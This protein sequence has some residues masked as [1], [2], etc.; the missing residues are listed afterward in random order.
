M[1]L[2]IEHASL[3]QLQETLPRLLSSL[4]IGRAQIVLEQ[5][6]SNLQNRPHDE[7]LFYL[8]RKESESELPPQV[9][10]TKTSSPIVPVNRK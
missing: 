2:K 9:D 10:Q 7:I 3:E 6:R 4:S 8:A 5:L 1:S